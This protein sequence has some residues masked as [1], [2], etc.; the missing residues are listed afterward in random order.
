V[1]SLRRHVPQRTCV[2]CRGV[3]PKRELHRLVRGGDGQV[4]YDADGRA[5]G[6]GAYVCADCLGQ[7]FRQ[8]R[9]E[10]A[11][12]GKI[13]AENMVRLRLELGSLLKM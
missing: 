9:L 8:N 2:I 5:A 7:D 6:R 10:Y 13:G 12:R 1:N 4:N 3:K 11:L